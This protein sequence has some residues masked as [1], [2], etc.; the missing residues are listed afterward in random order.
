MVFS[1]PFCNLPRKLIA[2][3]FYID[4]ERISYLRNVTSRF[5][6]L[7]AQRKLS[8][9]AY[10]PDSDLGGKCS[11]EIRDSCLDLGAKITP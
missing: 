7:E 10:E 8:E 11:G 5:S 4:L 1:P 9:I 2:L 6:N 3:F